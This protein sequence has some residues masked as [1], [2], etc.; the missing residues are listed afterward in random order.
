[1]SLIGSFLFAQ[2]GLMIYGK[3]N[4]EGGPVKGSKIVI[5]K[6]GRVVETLENTSKFE[7]ELDLGAQYI[8]E[9]Q[10]EGYVTKSVSFNTKVPPDRAELGFAP[11]GFNVT[12][13]KQYEGVNIIVFNQPVGKIRFNPDIDDFDYDTDY[14]K[15][16]QAAL[17]Q[18]EEE[19]KEEQRKEEERKKEEEKRKK[20]EEEAK[21]KAEEEAKK[22]AEEEAKR[23]AE[24]E[25]I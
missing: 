10:K 3:L 7:Y 20:A 17:Q 5:K 14:T 1:M 15:S 18:A 16:I 8:L 2:E 12:L 21:K 9:F 23:K 24:E 19:L 4:I 13:F 25:K 11:F 6:N 22:K